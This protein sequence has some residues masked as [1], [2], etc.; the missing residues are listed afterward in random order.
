MRKHT[1]QELV[2]LAALKH[3]EVCVV[4]AGA[5]QCP[6]SP[7]ACDKC[8]ILHVTRAAILEAELCE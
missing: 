6:P 2:M 1:P 7:H 4:A 3:I 8:E 5:E